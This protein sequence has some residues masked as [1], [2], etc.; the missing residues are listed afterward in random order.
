MSTIK[1]NINS[2]DLEIDFDYK[3]SSPGRHENGLQ[4]TPDDPEEVEIESIHVENSD[5]DIQEL[6]DES[7]INQIY[8]NLYL[9]IH[10]KEETRSFYLR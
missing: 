2:V 6:F 4:V 7:E 5:V 3:K 1:M 10:K 8:Y 9:A